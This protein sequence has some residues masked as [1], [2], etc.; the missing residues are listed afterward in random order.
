MSSHTTALPQNHEG[1][2]QPGASRLFAPDP[3]L[4]RS[5]ALTNNGKKATTLAMDPMKKFLFIVLLP[6]ITVFDK[7]WS[8][9]E[10][11]VRIQD[12]HTNARARWIRTEVIQLTTK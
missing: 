1:F 6:E 2:D 12:V 8:V 9:Y 10:E 3:P 4:I 5:S 7:Y 11:K